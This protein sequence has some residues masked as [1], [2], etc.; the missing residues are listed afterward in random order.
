LLA[1]ALSA[2]AQSDFR[3]AVWG[4]TQ[5]QVR[6]TE[7][8]GPSAVDQSNGSVILRYDSL[9]LGPL[10]CRV[11]YIFSKDRL[12]RAKYL[13]D[14]QHSDLNDFIRDFKS[15][16][17]LLLEKHGKPSTERAIWE[18]DSTQLEPKSYLDQDRAS[19]ASILPSDPNVGLAISLGHLRL[20]AQWNAARATV[21]HALS[22][23]DGQITHQVEYHSVELL[24]ATGN[25]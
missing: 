17:P 10:D 20:Y 11:I 1:G 13:F 5:S 25:Q 15:I 8:V 4:M 22:G 19:P 3:K 24:P 21:V 23:R 2:A 16:E 9:R 12:V 7:P 6:A 14:A 18:D